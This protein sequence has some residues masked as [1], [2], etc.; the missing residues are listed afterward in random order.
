MREKLYFDV[1]VIGGG[2]GG[3]I[4]AI[5]AARNGAKTILI[6][7]SGYLGG[8]LT[9]AGVAP[10]MTFH[11]QGKQVIHG[12]ADELVERMKSQGY[13]I[14]HI[15]DMSKY[16]ATITPFDLEGLKITLEEM[17]IESG[18]TL[19][20]HTVFTD[21]RVENKRILSAT[22]F[23][24]GGYLEIM[25]DV[26]ID[27][28]ADADL[29]VCAGVPTVMGREDGLT[30]PMTLN[31]KV[32]NVDS[33]KLKSYIRENPDDFYCKDPDVVDATPRVV[34]S[35]AYSLLEK[36]KQV[37][38][39][40]INR[41]TV[42]AFEGNSKGEY[43]INI[44]R[45][46]KK[47]VLNAFDLTE[48]EIQG[49]RQVREV[50]AFMRK[51]IP[52][53]ENCIL[54][55]TGPNIG[56]RESRRIIGNYTLTGADLLNSVMFDDAISMGA[57]PI[58]IHSPD[59]EASEHSHLKPGMWYSIPY[60]ITFNDLIENLLVTGRCVSADH[61]ALAAIRTTPI[62]M[63]FSQGVGTAAAMAVKENHGNVTTID[64]ATLRDKLSTQGVFLENCRH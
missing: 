62:V 51:Y 6:E 32:Y 4:A 52:G 57:Y 45:I 42:L 63:G 41:E 27:A 18:V 54:Y 49:R 10:M 8:M 43:T 39:F 46:A 38:D 50:V 1:A 11:T 20:Y 25:A 48:A 23:T 30:Q 29:A 61:E 3:S 60:T 58:D 31:A 44:T 36:A 28:T 40:T 55:A 37:G 9:K 53:F 59:G 5:S 21:C 33:E 26:F 24:K 35:G 22:V 47:S 13:S 34:L 64:I 7:A 15:P 12:I 16:C 17:A 19:L 2:P 56:V 14:G